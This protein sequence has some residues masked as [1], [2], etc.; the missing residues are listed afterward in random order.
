M[1][2][3]KRAQQTAAKKSVPEVTP[4]VT[5]EAP[6]QLTSKNTEGSWQAPGRKGE[7]PAPP[8]GIAPPEIE[9]TTEVEAF[10]NNLPGMD[11]VPQAGGMLDP[12]AAA[13]QKILAQEARTGQRKLDDRVKQEQRDQRALVHN[14]QIIAQSGLMSEKFEAYVLEMSQAILSPH[15]LL[16]MEN[17]RKRTHHPNIWRMWISKIREAVQHNTWAPFSSKGSSVLDQHLGREQQLK[18]QCAICHLPLKAS[19]MGQKFGCGAASRMFHNGLVLTRPLAELCPEM[20]QHIEANP[21]WANKAMGI[22]S[23]PEDWNETDWLDDE[24]SEKPRAQD[25]D[26]EEDRQ[27]AD[28]EGTTEGPVS[29]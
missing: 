11:S 18:T 15:E 21:A 6:A 4:E 24:G 2:K 7:T 19:L 10:M 16:M 13:V 17:G 23:L 29:A 22:Q 12:E 27:E 3:T 1:A 28:S 8:K 5:P 26:Q 9:L 20:I 25:A 14:E